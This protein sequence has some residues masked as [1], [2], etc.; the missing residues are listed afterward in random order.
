MHR[1]RRANLELLAVAVQAGKSWSGLPV[2]DPN[3]ALSGTREDLS[4]SGERDTIRLGE[5][6]NLFDR[7]L[8]RRR[9]LGNLLWAGEFTFGLVY[10][11]TSDNFR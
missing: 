10:P 5:G 1:R 9:S 6:K 3:I 4:R 8:G 2:F 11:F 7:I